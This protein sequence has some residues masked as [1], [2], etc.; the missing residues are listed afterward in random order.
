M[1]IKIGART[2]EIQ[3]EDLDNFT[4]LPADEEVQGYIDY[5][6]SKIVINN[7]LSKDAEEEVVIHEILHAIIDR[8]NIELLARKSDIK[9]IV[10]HFVEYVTPRFHSFLKDNPEFLKKFI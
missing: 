7:N 2:Y 8:K 5:Y 6:Q 1:Q 3:K 4:D 9:E 10:E